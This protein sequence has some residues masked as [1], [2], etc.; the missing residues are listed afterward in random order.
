MMFKVGEI[1]VV[2]TSQFF[3]SKNT[4]NTNFTR[5]FV[6]N[7]TALQEQLNKYFD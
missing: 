7:D 3:I 5:W 1:T 6:N 2:A 4:P